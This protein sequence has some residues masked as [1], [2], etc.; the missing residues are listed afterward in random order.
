MLRRFSE[1]RE[2]DVIDVCTGRRVGY[3]GDLEI[4]PEGKI[5]AVL[6]SPRFLGSPKT[7]VRIPWNEICCIGE[8]TILVKVPEGAEKPEKPK[9]R[10]GIFG[11]GGWE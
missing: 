11:L 1:L 10:K 9:S 6:V 2:K 7:F 4:T 8:D 3:L 5:A